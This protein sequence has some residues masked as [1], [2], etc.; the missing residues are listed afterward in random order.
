MM[1][2]RIYTWGGPLVHGVYLTKTVAFREGVHLVGH[3]LVQL[4]DLFCFAV[5]S[6]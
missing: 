3:R 6:K 5:P 4:S 2:I 1:I